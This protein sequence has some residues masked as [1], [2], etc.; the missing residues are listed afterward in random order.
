MSSR[1]QVA[2]GEGAARP[3]EA[4]TMERFGVLVGKDGGAKLT[5]L[6]RSAR[7]SCGHHRRH[8]D[9]PG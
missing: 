1:L 8:A 9:A 7:G 4:L 5:R 2:R 6:G 3:L